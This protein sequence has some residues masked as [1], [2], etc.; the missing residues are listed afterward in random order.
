MTS[1]KDALHEFQALDISIGPRNQ[2]PATAAAFTGTVISD[3][4]MPDS[5]P[6]ISQVRGIV[7][8]SRSTLPHIVTQIIIQ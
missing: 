4:R 8:V 7:R 1:Y 3:M 6:M 2:V 5:I